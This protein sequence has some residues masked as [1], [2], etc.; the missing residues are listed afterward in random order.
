MTGRGW[1]TKKGDPEGHRPEIKG[2]PF[3]VI[4][5]LGS[6]LS[7]QKCMEIANRL[8]GSSKVRLGQVRLAIKIYMTGLTF[9]LF[10][11]MNSKMMFLTFNLFK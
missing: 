5:P 9:I 8:V 7:Q 11:I 6:E 2:P 4:H 10:F 1:V 3:Y